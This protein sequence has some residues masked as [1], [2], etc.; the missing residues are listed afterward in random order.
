V[1]RHK[2]E[3]V[4]LSEGVGKLCGEAWYTGITYVTFVTPPI[5]RRWGEVGSII[6]L[7]VYLPVVTCIHRVYAKCP[8]YPLSVSFSPIDEVRTI[9]ICP[10]TTFVAERLIMTTRRMYL[11]KRNLKGTWRA[12]SSHFPSQKILA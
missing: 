4:R 6:L 11:K 8:R 10:Q 3:F 1:V 12:I 5:N 2:A 9:S 7:E